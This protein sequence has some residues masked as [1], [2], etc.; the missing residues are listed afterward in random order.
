M[1]SHWHFSFVQYVH[2]AWL[3]VYLSH[4]SWHFTYMYTYMYE[5]LWYLTSAHEG[6]SGN[7]S[8][9]IVDPIS[10][11]PPSTVLVTPSVDLL[12]PTGEE[13]A[14]SMWSSKPCESLTIYRCHSKC[15]TSVLSYYK[16]LRVGLSGIRTRDLLLCMYMYFMYMYWNFFPVLLLFM[17]YIRGGFDFLVWIKSFNVS[18]QLFRWF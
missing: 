9:S 8:W 5:K 16:A 15:S 1:A 12:H 2:W 7:R 18:I 3:I 10:P 14:I 11:T 4:V 17:L 13:T 6:A